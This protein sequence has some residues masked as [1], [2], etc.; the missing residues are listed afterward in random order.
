MFTI[1]KSAIESSKSRLNTACYHVL[2]Q[3]TLTIKVRS[4]T[5][6]LPSLL[7]SL[8]HS[9]APKLA[10]VTLTVVFTGAGAVLLSGCERLS[11]ASIQPSK[12]NDAS[13]IT[14][15]SQ[16]RVVDANL[17]MPT[18]TL[19]CSDIDSQQVITVK[20]HLKLAK[21][22]DLTGKGVRFNLDSTN[23]SFDCNGAVLSALEGD[24]DN[25]SAI[26]IAPKTD[27]A[28]GNI[29]VA[30]C[31]VSGYGHALHIRQKTNPNVR[32]AKGF[33]DPDANRALAPHDI[34]IVNLSSTNSGNS[35]IFV[36]DHVHH[37]SFDKLTIM[38]SGT[39]GLY[40][41][42]GSQYNT[43]Q[44]SVFADNG[45]RSFK[46]NREAIAVDSSSFNTIKD[47]QFIHNGAGAVFLYRNC[48]EHANDASQSNHFK[49]TESAANNIISGNTF[50]DEPVGVW[51][52]SRQSRNLKGFECGAYPL[53]ETMLASYYIDS[54]KNNII[55]DNT[56]INIDNGII[57]EDDGTQII[58]NDF[59]QI[60]GTPYQVG[61]EIRQKYADKVSGLSPDIKGTLIEGNKL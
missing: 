42:F 60:R 46:P 18:Q 49:R 47:N 45:Y 39:V 32:Y 36:G 21:G 40:L 23:T 48:F 3:Q 26:T 61:S 43:V 22:C 17:P 12:D 54:A 27:Q 15:T 30:N 58:D 56:F 6:L 51:V 19:N 13:H 2:K 34:R 5:P 20:G 10:C 33:I 31:H 16:T 25:K 14:A 59:R 55:K 1:C 4:K 28:I 8:C 9:W 7:N 52:A 50:R 44:N 38:R 11:T 29:A 57:V 37:V 24:Q 41:E 35:G 53:A